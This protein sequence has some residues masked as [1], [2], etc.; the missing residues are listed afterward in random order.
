MARLRGSSFLKGTYFVL[1]VHSS[2]RRAHGMWQRD[3]KESLRGSASRCAEVQ[4]PLADR[5]GWFKARRPLRSQPAMPKSARKSARA[6]SSETFCTHSSCRNWVGVFWV[7]HLPCSADLF[8][9]ST[10][11]RQ[12]WGRQQRTGLTTPRANNNTARHGSHASTEEAVNENGF[13]RTQE[14]QPRCTL[15]PTST[16]HRHHITGNK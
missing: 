1:W 2:P 16:R 9:K 7:F 5:L 3:G 14:P 13:A 11:W 8:S 10:S 6:I 12:E 4:R 15:K